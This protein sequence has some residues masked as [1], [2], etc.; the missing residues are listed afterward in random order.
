MYGVVGLGPEEG[1]KDGLEHLPYK[2]RQ[3]ELGL[4]C[5]EN[6]PRR[7]YSNLP[8][9]EGAYGKAGRDIL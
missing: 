2:D 7:P 1:H 5:L 4:F 9:P 3:N 6:A 8:A